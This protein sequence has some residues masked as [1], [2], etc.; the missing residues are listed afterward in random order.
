MRDDD[1][2]GRVSAV[3]CS[4]ED[5]S[6][7][8]YTGSK[9]VLDADGDFSANRDMMYRYAPKACYIADEDQRWRDQLRCR[10]PVRRSVQGRWP[11]HGPV[12][13]RRFPE[14]P[15]DSCAGPRNLYSNFLGLLVNTNGQRFMNENCLS[16]CAG[17]NNYGQPGKTVFAL[18][19]RDYASQVELSGTTIPC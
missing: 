13:W 6:Y 15:A 4:R 5:G 3:I 7:A 17:M 14:L 9:A 19:G 11:A 12:G 1:G 18:W 16:P 8:K 10:V 2:N